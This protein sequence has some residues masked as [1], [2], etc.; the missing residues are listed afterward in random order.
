MATSAEELERELVDDLEGLQERFADEEFSS[1]L[2]RALANNVWRKDG[3]P[4][5]V[6][7]SWS[8]AEQVVNELRGR[9]DEPRLE[10]AQ[11]GGEGEISPVV[12][13]ELRRLGWSASALDTSRRHG[14]HLAQPESPPPAEQ[15]ERQAPVGDSDEWERTAHEEAEEERLRR[16]GGVSP[17]ASE[18]M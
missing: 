18:G 14:T 11:T 7:L 6:S 4:G 9:R 5:D 2:Y 13:E 17:P 16:L 3:R 10:L 15:G 8:R 1:E 12:E